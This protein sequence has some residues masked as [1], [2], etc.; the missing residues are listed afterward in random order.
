M[1]KKI[2]LSGL[3]AVAFSSSIFAD[4]KSKKAIAKLFTS[5]VA[6]VN[7]STVRIQADGKDVAL[8]TVV[9]SAGYIV[10]KAS[11]IKGTITVKLRDGSLIDATYIGFHNGTDIAVLKV[12]SPLTPIKFADEDKIAVGNF[13]A[14][15]GMDDEP[16]AIGIISVGIRALVGLETRI[17]NNNKGFLGISMAESK[18]KDGVFVTGFSSEGI[19]ES[20]AK[21]A[22]LEE[23]DLI[24]KVNDKT[25]NTM[26]DMISTMDGFKPNE[27]IKLLVKR[28]I[29]KSDVD[30]LE[31]KVKLMPKSLLDR[32]EY[33][34][35]LG[36][37][38]SSR[39]SG[40]PKIIQHDSVI[41]PIDCGGPIV[42][43][44]GN[45]LGINIARAGRVESWALPPD[46]VKKYFVEIKEGKHSS[47]TKKGE[48][49]NAEPKKDDKNSDK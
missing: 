13:I 22:G 10:T 44:E 5:S 45:V 37:M 30:E 26:E 24:V 21:K 18:K 9:D 1:F 41:K 47:P 6:K 43:L 20:A 49:K 23:S 25:I 16:V 29:D 36:S 14:T 31:I 34:N 48:Q 42:D 35:R 17:E 12:D 40:F 19:A 7:E 38:L 8:G 32:S 4:V 2:L 3:F 46:L 28:K 39:R 15:P 11:E 27:T 33:Q